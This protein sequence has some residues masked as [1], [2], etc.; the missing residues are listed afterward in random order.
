MDDF[1]VTNGFSTNGKL[2]EM[3]LITSA[4]WTV[5]A[6]SMLRVDPLHQAPSKKAD[7]NKNP[8]D[9]NDDKKNE[10][11][12]AQ[13]TKEIERVTNDFPVIEIGI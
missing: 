11:T 13:E 9:K 12:T 10:K 8:S 2:V 7:Q 5:I 3:N 4:Q 6:R 1:I